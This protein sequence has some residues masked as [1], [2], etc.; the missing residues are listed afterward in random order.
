MCC[1]WF[2][3]FYSRG[4]KFNH[5]WNKERFYCSGDYILE[6]G[7]KY[8]RKIHGSEQVKIG[9][10]GVGNLEQVVLGNH[11]YISDSTVKGSI[12]HR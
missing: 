2:K 3:C 10:S 7:G 4:C 8:T 11:G 9:V 12:E 6:V 5:L 1:R